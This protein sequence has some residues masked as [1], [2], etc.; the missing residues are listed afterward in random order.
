MICWGVQFGFLGT[1][2]G[3]D[4]KTGIS[5]YI[6]GYIAYGVTLVSLNLPH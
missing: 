3:N 4:W 2:D 6:V 1:K 5:L